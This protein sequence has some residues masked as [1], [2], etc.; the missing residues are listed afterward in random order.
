M[1]S[2]KDRYG[3]ESKNTCEEHKKPSVRKNRPGSERSDCV[4]HSPVGTSC[5]CPCFKSDRSMCHVNVSRQQLPDS[6][7]KKPKNGIFSSLRRRLTSISNGC[8][9]NEQ[10]HATSL[11]CDEQCCRCFLESK[12]KSQRS[13]SADRNRHEKTASS[14]SKTLP[15]SHGSSKKSNSVTLPRRHRRFVKRE[16]QELQCSSCLTDDSEDENAP[17]TLTSQPQPS[18]RRRVKVKSASSCSKSTSELQAPFDG[19]GH[20]SSPRFNEVCDTHSI[21]GASSGRSVQLA[22]SEK[23]LTDPSDAS[24]LDIAPATLTRDLRTVE[25]YDHVQDFVREP[26][27][28]TKELLKLVKCGWYWGPIDRL[29]AEEKLGQQPDGAFLVRDSSDERY[30]LTLSFRSYGRT[31]HTRIEHCNGVFSF[32]AQSDCDG[33]SSVEELIK[34]S[35]NNSDSDV[36]YYSRAPTPGSPSI[37]VRLIKPVSRFTQVRS[38]Q[39]LCRFVI[40]QTTRVDHIVQLPLPK[41]LKGWLQQKQY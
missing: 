37:P 24:E 10:P 41:S 21:S 29:E 25:H 20:A 12:S 36:F 38:L 31:L 26:W 2:T 16:K 1:K 34:H 15:R 3:L 6:P 33:Y 13:R 30:L 28:L 17:L 32:Y 8:W 14:S 23:S 22:S 27:S 40:R 35:M 4:V 9:S 39:Y 7:K 5:L 18:P 19:Y 11:L